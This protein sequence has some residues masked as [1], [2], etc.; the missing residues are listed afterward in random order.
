MRRAIG[1]VF[2]IFTAVSLAGMALLFTVVA[3]DEIGGG[4][5]TPA[6]AVI[7]VA[8][9]GI[10]G[11]LVLGPVGRATGRLIEGEGGPDDTLR[12]TVRDLED[13]IHELS[14]DG[15]R[16]LDL[17]ERLEFTERLLAR[18]SEEQRS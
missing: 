15:Q 14:L 2:G 8:G 13:R 5:L 4:D 11:S 17:E 7:V 10:F 18:Q 16:L 12:E 3:V 1:R 6:V 9:V